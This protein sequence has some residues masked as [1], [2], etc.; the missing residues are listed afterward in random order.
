MDPVGND[1]RESMKDSHSAGTGCYKLSENVSQQ[2]VFL[3]VC[4]WM[5]RSWRHSSEDLNCF[6]YPQLPFITLAAGYFTLSG[7]LRPDWDCARKVYVGM[8]WG[9]GWATDFTSG[10]ELVGGTAETWAHR[11]PAGGHRVSSP[12]SK[13]CVW[14]SL[15][16]AGHHTVLLANGHS[17]SCIKHRDTPKS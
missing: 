7:R 11:H 6:L 17:L 14:S 15:L 4:C 9:G 3:L 16:R 1:S 13:P 5:N 12:P 8:G 2:M 10:F